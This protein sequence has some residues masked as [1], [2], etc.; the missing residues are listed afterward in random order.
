M[1]P[2]VHFSM[3]KSSFFVIALIVLCAL[4]SHGQE[5]PG[6]T[7][8]SIRLG[9]CSALE[10]PAAFLGTQMQLGAL[11]YIRGVNDH[12]GVY[13]R[14]I[15]L[16]FH[17][18]SYDPDEATACFNRLKKESVF[19]MG[20]FV[21]TAPAAKYVPM[22]EREK[23]PVVGL[24]TGAQ[25]LYEPLKHY[26]LNIRASY[27]DEVRT[28]VDKLWE[29]RG[30]RKIGV[31]YQEDAFGKT[32]L[33]GVQFA[34]VSHHAA[35]AALGTF[36]R[37]TLDV[38]AGLKKVQEAKP[39]AVILVG[40][41]APVAAILKQS[42]ASGW[43]PLFL[44]VSFVGT[45]GLIRAAGKDADGVIVTQ[46]LPSYDRTDLPTIKNYRAAIDTYGSS[47][48]FVSLEGFVDAMVLVEGLK[49][50][51]KEPTREGLI[52]AIE[53]LHGT[54]IGLG[55][56]FS[57]NYGPKEHKG[58]HSV[59]PTIIRNGTAVALRDWKNLANN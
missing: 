34:L 35:P 25:M 27:Y 5:E 45:E 48:T 1:T 4:G 43:S 19:A 21:G 2:P 42:H 17:D 24:F 51:G 31:I 57:L 53:S 49:R 11:A 55:P 37:N 47:P 59:Y 40:P 16:K 30:V 58:L 3:T 33:D 8:T 46:V 23:I 7:A 28:Q 12:G 38:A 41:Y 9:S 44:T 32:V 36:P 29:V 13:G 39:D 56:E 20:F 14:K 54:D 18:D 10:G 15:E 52:A 26:V 50:A 6:L 22:A